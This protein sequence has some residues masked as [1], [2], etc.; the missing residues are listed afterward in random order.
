[1]VTNG[2]RD[3]SLVNNNIKE[4]LEIYI[5]IGKPYSPQLY[6]LWAMVYEN[7]AKRQLVILGL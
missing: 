6:I 3:S 7:E 1:L 5:M 4:E 2:Y